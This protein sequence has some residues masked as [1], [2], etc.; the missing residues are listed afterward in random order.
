MNIQEVPFNE[1]LGI[2]PT[3]KEGFILELTNNDHLSN[4]LGTLH[5]GALFSLAEATSGEFLLRKFQ[6]CELNLIP[7]VRKVDIKYSKPG[8]TVVY[9]TA[10][11]S[12]CSM[13]EGYAELKEKGRV[14]IKVKVS[15]YNESKERIAVSNI[16][17]FLALAQ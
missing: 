12:E 6:S 4:H 9:S 3:V 7:V 14:M 5:A 16:H 17:W 13:E 8:E 1:F 15:L 2:L 10:D 11:F